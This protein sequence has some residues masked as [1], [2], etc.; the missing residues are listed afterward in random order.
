MKSD[1]CYEAH[2]LNEDGTLKY[3]CGLDKRYK[4]LWDGT[5]KDSKEYKEALA[6]YIPVAKQF[7]AEGAKN[8]DGTLFEFN[9][10]EPKKLPRAYTVQEAESRKDVADSLYGYYDHT[11]KALFFGTYLGSL[12]G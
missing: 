7:M 2:S 1:G 12:I 8:D 9:V 10:T 3:D 4:A 11:K 6:R 5:P